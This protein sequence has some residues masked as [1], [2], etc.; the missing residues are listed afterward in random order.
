M[1][2]QLE[3]LINPKP[4]TQVPQPR[5]S[6]SGAEM[7]PQPGAAAEVGGEGGG[8]SNAACIEMLPVVIM[9]GGRTSRLP[10]KKLRLAS[11]P[12]PPCIQP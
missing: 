11:L 9:E 4:E 3:A 8:R 2:A 6:L 12:V 7:Q 10:W 1:A 5:I